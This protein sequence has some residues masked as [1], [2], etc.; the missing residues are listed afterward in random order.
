[1]ISCQ[2]FSPSWLT[3]V[4]HEKTLNAFASLLRLEVIKKRGGRGDS[5]QYLTIGIIIIMKEFLTNQNILNISKITFFPCFPLHPIY[6][7]YTLKPLFPSYITYPFLD[8][9]IKNEYKY[10]FSHQYLFKLLYF[11][12]YF[13]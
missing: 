5:K 10:T 2:G 6:L 1:M 9:I 7:F 13:E 3:K 8:R 11:T 12:L 4:H